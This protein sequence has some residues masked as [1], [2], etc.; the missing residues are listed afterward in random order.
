MT[1]QLAASLFLTYYLQKVLHRSP[2]ASGLG[3]LPI[4][5]TTTAATQL[6][7]RLLPRLVSRA[8]NSMNEAPPS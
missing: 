7:T 4:S 2:M 6:G 1:T 3:F 5:L 8:R